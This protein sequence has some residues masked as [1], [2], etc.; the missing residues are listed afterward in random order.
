M[1]P[2]KRN[3]SFCGSAEHALM[4]RRTFLGTSAAVA[5]GMAGISGLSSQSIA[6]EIK[7]NDKRVIMLWLA[8]GASQL[9]TWDPKPGRPTGGPFMPIQTTVPGLHI[10]EMMP[11]MAKRL[12]RHTAVIR[13][14]NTRDGGH[15][16]A[17]D[18]MMHGRKNEPTLKYPDL[19]AMLAYELGKSDSQVPDYVSVYSQTEG[20]RNGGLGPGFLGA[21]Y[22]PII[23]KDKMELP[24]IKRLE[25]ISKL[26]H[27]ERADLRK[28]LSDRF[29]QGRGSNPVNSHSTAYDRVDGL[30][31]SDKLFDIS[32]EPQKVRDRDGR[33]QLGD[34][35]RVVAVD[36]RGGVRG[37]EVDT[38]LV[39]HSVFLLG[40]RAGRSY[41]PPS[42]YRKVR[43]P[44]VDRFRA[45]RRALVS[46]RIP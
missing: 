26:D 20:Q 18:L 45:R 37:A 21:R 11:Q 8:G 40:R 36:R 38:Q 6:G 39:A 17:A 5:G 25:S 19:G 13:S 42:P 23:L 41:P 27:R 4:P 28:L 14:L 16:T 1:P 7:K 12:H 44:R 32:Q 9:E 35:T 2:T 33:S 30:M 34:L 43:G 46:P 24:N 22:G 31:A 10:S 3:M 29:V 15:G